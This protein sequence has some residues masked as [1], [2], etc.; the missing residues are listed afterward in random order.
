MKTGP[1]IDRRCSIPPTSIVMAGSI[2]GV[3]AEIGAPALIW[4]LQAAIAQ[5][6]RPRYALA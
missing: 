2:M 3:P 1:K 6:M 4:R 5:G